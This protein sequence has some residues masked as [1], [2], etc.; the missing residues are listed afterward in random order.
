MRNAR[1]QYSQDS[2]SGRKHPLMR[3][4]WDMESHAA[5]EYIPPRKPPKAR[6]ENKRKK[7]ITRFKDAANMDLKDHN[8]FHTAASRALTD[9][10]QQQQ[11]Q[12]RDSFDD[13]Q[14]A[15]YKLLKQAPVEAT[16]LDQIEKVQGGL[17]KGARLRD[18]L[19]AIE[20][21]S[22]GEHLVQEIFDR[23]K[24]KFERAIGNASDID[25]L[26][27]EGGRLLEICFCGRSNVGKSSLINS[28]MGGGKARVS[29]R[30]GETRTINFYRMG[31]AF[32]AVDLPGYGFAFASEQE[33]QQWIAL[34]EKYIKERAPDVLKRVFVLIDSRHG[35]KQSD[36]QFLHFLNKLSG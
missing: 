31:D 28:V 20:K 11:Q 5:D 8:I 32:R 23:R 17:R 34:M 22:R 7:N 19:Q 29:N 12:Q 24:F 9:R 26:Q 35:L 30:P 6:S 10:Q 18:A 15:N 16:I 2:K 36:I 3:D 21:K 1:R 33:S 27:S 25:P 13:A 14:P 4:D